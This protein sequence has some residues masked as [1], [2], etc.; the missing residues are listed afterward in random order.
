MYFLGPL[1]MNLKNI[2]SSL[3]SYQIFCAI[4]RVFLV[5]FLHLVFG[6]GLAPILAPPVYLCTMVKWNIE[7]MMNFTIQLSTFS[8]SNSRTYLFVP[9]AS[10][11]SNKNWN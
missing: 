9:L 11:C 1:S 6:P 10:F 5:V 4:T 7:P 3:Q 8:Q 2:C